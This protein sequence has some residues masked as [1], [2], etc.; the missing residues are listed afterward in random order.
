MANKTIGDLVAV[1]G[2]PALTDILEQETDPA[3]T[4]ASEKVTYQKIKNTVDG[5]LSTDDREFASLVTSGDGSTTG[6]TITNTPDGDIWLKVNSAIELV[7]DNSLLKSSYFSN[8][9]GTTSL[10]ISAV[11]SGD[12][13]Y[14]NGAVA[15]YE[16][17]VT[18]D[19]GLIYEV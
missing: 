9:G 5:N 12:T 8:D 7:G 19:C 4:P 16:L 2:N 11:Q 1:T 17:A 15:N 13:L 6:K 14:W 18:D 10:A 3:G